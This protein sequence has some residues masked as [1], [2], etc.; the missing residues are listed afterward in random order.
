MRL[1]VIADIHGNSLALEAVLADMKRVGFGRGVDLAAP[2]PSDRY[3]LVEL[4]DSGAEVTF[5]LAAYGH[6]AAARQA[7]VD[8][9][10]DWA[11][12]LRT[13]FVPRSSA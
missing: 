10:L 13:G 2:A 3:A 9:R 1:A 8:D 6:E 12:A 5:R 11:H 7:T 4:S